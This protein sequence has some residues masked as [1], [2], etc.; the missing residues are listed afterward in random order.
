MI[1]AQAVPCPQRSPSVVLRPR[2]LVVLSIEIATG[3]CTSPTSGWPARCRCRGCRRDAGAGRAAPRPLARDLARARPR[4]ARSRSTASAGRLQAGSGSSAIG[5]RGLRPAERR[6]VR[7]GARFLRKKPRVLYSECFRS[8]TRSLPAPVT[9]I[10][11]ARRRGSG[12]PRSRQRG[13]E[14]AGARA[15]TP[16]WHFAGAGQGRAAAGGSYRLIYSR[17]SPRR[18]SAARAATS[19]SS[20]ARRTRVVVGGNREVHGD[21]L[22]GRRGRGGSED[23]RR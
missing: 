4:A 15:G 8:L 3:R 9:R 14:A 23:P 12:L 13:P 19:A 5:L 6:S 2:H 10:F 17:A 1:P 22:G 7:V 21:E 11:S 18:T 20:S 16:G